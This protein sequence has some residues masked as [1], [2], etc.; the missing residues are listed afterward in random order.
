MTVGPAACVNYLT[1]S[2]NSAFAATASDP[3]SVALPA[4]GVPPLLRAL[5]RPCGDFP[6]G[7]PGR[8]AP[9]LPDPDMVRGRGERLAQ[10][11]DLGASP[12]QPLA[13]GN[14]TRAAVGLS[15]KLQWI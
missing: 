12:R 13:G 2:K 6:G 7:G 10:L 9:V 8:P 5:E 11:E 14:V 3:V 15:L 4:G 1:L